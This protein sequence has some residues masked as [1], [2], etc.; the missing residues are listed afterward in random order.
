MAI[1]DDSLTISG[2]LFHSFGPAREKDLELADR[3]GLCSQHHKDTL[4]FVL[5]MY[6]VVCQ[7]CILSAFLSPVKKISQAYYSGGIQ[8]HDL[9]N[10]RAVSYQLDYRDC[11]VAGGSS[12]PMFKQWVRPTTLR[13]I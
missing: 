11:P 7:H 3:E 4:I 10:S 2:N 5:L 8:N 12:N 9:C 6:T 1:E 13:H